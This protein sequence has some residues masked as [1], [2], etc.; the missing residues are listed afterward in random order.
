MSEFKNCEQYVLAELEN[1]KLEIEEL[2]ADNDSLL[3]ELNSNEFVIDKLKN[4]IMSIGS[5]VKTTVDGKSHYSAMFRTIDS[6]K[7]KKLFQ[8]LMRFVLDFD[9][10]D[11]LEVIYK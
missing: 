6:E 1:A 4:V 3:S 9:D 5:L 11:V 10:E 2:K 8:D 7:D